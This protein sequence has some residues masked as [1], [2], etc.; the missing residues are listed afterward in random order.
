MPKVSPTEEISTGRSGRVRRV[1][2]SM[3]E[4]N[5]V[6]LVDV[7]LVLLIIFMVTAPMLQRGVDVNLPV[8]RRA[9]AIAEERV[10]LTVPL[11]YRKDRAVRLGTERIA[12]DVLAERV[13]QMMDGR[14]DRKVFL[15]GDG[16]ILLQELLEVM[17]RLKEAGIEQ[18]GIVAK[19]PEER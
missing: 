7:M 17:D 9:E 6:P 19:L 5:V 8:A 13:R 16:G 1:T 14:D 10:F 4:I 2:S 15:R 11:T 18:V 3:S 12:I